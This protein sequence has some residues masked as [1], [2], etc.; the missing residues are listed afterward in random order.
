MKKK[1][2]TALISISLIFLASGIYIITNI[3]KSTSTLDYLIKLH[4]VEILREHLLLQIKK[5]QSDLILWETQHARGLDIVIS[6]VR[7]MD[8]LTAAC[9]DCHHTPAVVKRLNNLQKEIKI[10]KDTYSMEYYEK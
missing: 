5:V 3:E 9:F 7:K 4:Q 10:Y 6:N 8:V 2:I 1:I